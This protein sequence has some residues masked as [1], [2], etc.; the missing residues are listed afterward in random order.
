MNYLARHP[1][2]QKYPG[3]WTTFIFDFFSR[4][5]SAKYLML[6]AGWQITGSKSSGKAPQS[7]AG[8][9]RSDTSI[10]TTNGR[11]TIPSAK[12]A[13]RFAAP[14]SRWRSS[15]QLACIGINRNATERPSGAAERSR[16]AYG[17]HAGRLAFT[18][19]LY[20]QQSSSKTGALGCC[21]STF[22]CQ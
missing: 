9:F 8:A 5:D 3:V 13:H 16:I 6:S 15:N 19:G 14:P 7:D 1:K 4:F 11:L 2:I 20:A 18:V 12:I 17:Q 22:F 21:G 10:G